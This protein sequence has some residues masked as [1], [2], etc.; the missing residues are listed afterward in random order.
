MRTKDG[1]TALDLICQRSQVT[2]QSQGMFAIES[3]QQEVIVQ[4][5]RN[6][7]GKSGAQPAEMTGNMNG[8][9]DTQVEFPSQNFGYP[10]HCSGSMTS[11]SPPY[12]VS[13]LGS[14]YSYNNS[15][16]TSPRTPP[17]RS[18]VSISNPSMN[19][20]GSYQQPS[21]ES[22]YVGSPHYQSSPHYQ[23]L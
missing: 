20:V 13:P 8:S 5:I 17:L 22:E 15:S 11:S 2:A 14:P 6:N 4:L 9:R 21:P 18:P 7:G 23:V 12:N 3:Q 16:M 1:L 10:A 19:S